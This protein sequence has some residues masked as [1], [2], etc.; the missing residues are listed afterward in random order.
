MGSH[1]MTLR[2]A[3]R[4]PLHWLRSILLA[5]QLAVA[6]GVA[7][8]LVLA[9]CSTVG[10]T[11]KGEYV[12]Q[13]RTYYIGADE[14][15]WNY[16]PSGMNRITGTV[17]DEE[18]AVFTQQGPQRIGTTY[19]KSLYR[20][21]T[22]TSFTSIKRRSA[23]DQ[24]L[25]ML[26]PLIRGV[27]GDT[28]K[29]V[30]K[31]NLDRAASVHAHG[32]FYDKSSEGAPYDDGTGAADQDDDAVPP[33]TLHTYSYEVPDRAGPGPMDGSSVMWITTRTRTRSPTTMPVSSVRW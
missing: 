31:N 4:G 20:E 9:G 27:V 2:Q 11:A 30:F 19:A 16:A 18:A 25:G 5:L 32:V 28:I 15:D 24:H 29:V 33:G 1:V 3:R 8:V 12:P 7:A 13:T 21:Y 22:D 6:A 10:T 17:F 26:G 23:P 14:V